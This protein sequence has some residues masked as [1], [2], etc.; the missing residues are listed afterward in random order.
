MP[1]NMMW[2]RKGLA[3]WRTT[4]K[5]TNK[6]VWRKKQGP[7]MTRSMM[8]RKGWSLSGGWRHYGAAGWMDRRAN[9][10]ALFI[11]HL[12]VIKLLSSLQSSLKLL[13]LRPF[14]CHQVV[15][16]SQPPYSA[17]K[18]ALPNL[19][20]ITTFRDR[21]AMYD[22]SLKCFGSPNQLKTPSW[23]ILFLFKCVQ[24]GG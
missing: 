16:D 21:E 1:R 13:L 5:Q 12:I 17:K 9:A 19:S 24:E 11:S 2:R 15:V 18:S 6:E 8:R 4:N 23:A 7:R 10:T 14:D 22:N 3:L 20:K